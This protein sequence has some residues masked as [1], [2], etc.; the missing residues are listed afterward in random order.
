MDILNQLGGLVLGSVPTMLFFVVLVIAYNVL[1]GKP[2][3]KTLAERHK[4]TTGAMDDARA[5]ISASEAKAAEYEAKLREARAAIFAS[6]QARL[7]QWNAE[8]E[9][10]L[11]EARKEAN[12]RIGAAREAVERSG[13]EAKVQLEQ[14]AAQLSTQILK[15][16][17]PKGS[18][19]AA[20][21]G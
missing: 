10:A 8:R 19:S 11:G 5:A 13:E 12:H 20:V 18:K 15:A 16:I 7:K 17:L 21:Q 6:R 2:L 1:V 3:E 4:R 9:K 14:A